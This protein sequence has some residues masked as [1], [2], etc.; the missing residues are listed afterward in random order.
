VTLTPEQ[1]ALLDSRPAL[2]KPAN[3]SIDKTIP[4]HRAR[5]LVRVAQALYT[6]WHTGDDQWLVEA[7]DP[8]YVD[9]TLPLGNQQGTIS[10]RETSARLR[11]AIPDLGCELQDI[12][13][14]GDKMAT[15]IRF[16]GHFIGEFAE[17]KG[18]GQVIDFI[19][20]EIH[21]LGDDRIFESWH[22]EDHQSFL[23]QAGLAGG[24]SA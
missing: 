16:T 4:V 8:S 20:L 24:S 7:V 12:I 6:F 14:A 23:R 5:Q 11:Q 2:V 19:A 15:R 3:M 10:L 21:H 13:V 17:S 9:N 18:D 22:V 1:A